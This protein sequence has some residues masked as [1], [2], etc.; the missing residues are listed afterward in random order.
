MYRIE[1]CNGQVQI[2]VYNKQRIEQT[3][4]N[5]NIQLH[6]QYI[7]YLYP[8]TRIWLQYIGRCSAT[9]YAGIFQTRQAAKSLFPVNAA[10]QWEL[11]YTVYKAVTVCVTRRK[12]AASKWYCLHEWNL[13]YWPRTKWLTLLFL[14][15]KHLFIIFNNLLWPG[16]V[17]F[18]THLVYRFIRWWWWWYNSF[19][20]A[21]WN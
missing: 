21:A 12:L 10:E 20:P 19:H 17:W 2:N 15:Y 1:H 9:F 8:Y 14:Q 16:D 6:L 3:E 7:I 11:Q 18:G 4:L 13:M 5:G